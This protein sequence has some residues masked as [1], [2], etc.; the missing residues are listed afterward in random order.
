MNT[1]ARTACVLALALCGWAGAAQAAIQIVGTR[2]I[3]PAGQREVTVSLLNNNESP[4]LLQAWVD[5]GDSTAT[6]DTAK[7]PFTVTPPMSRIDPGKGQSLRVIYT[8]KDLPQ[9]RES[10][11]WLNVL[12]IPPRPKAQEGESQ[13]FMQFAI[14]TRIKLFYRPKGLEGN[15]ADAYEKLSWR[16]VRQGS[17]YALECTNPS[18]F[19]V[20]FGSLRFKASDVART[21]VAGGGMCPARGTQLL[22]V[23]GEPAGGNRL[24][25][26]VINDYGGVDE[27]EASYAR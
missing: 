22:P 27:R 12:E 24:V 8:G 19:N 18:A 10:V 7:A 1:F 2:V 17:A 6:A 25:L 13:N 21:S 11:Y 20:S 4:R 14:R 26:D 5:D 23:E 9:D 3:Y 16:L 15:A